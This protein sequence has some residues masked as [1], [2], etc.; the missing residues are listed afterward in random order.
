MSDSDEFLALL[1]RESPSLLLAMTGLASAIAKRQPDKRA[2]ATQTLTDTLAKIMSGADVLGRQDVAEAHGLKP[3]GGRSVGG[4]GGG[5]VTMPPAGGSGGDSMLDSIMKRYKAWHAPTLADDASGLIE[6]RIKK[7]FEEG[8][9]SA[10]AVLEDV[11]DWTVAY[12][13]TVYRTNV[14]S[15]YAAGN[16]AESM[17]P[18]ILE[19]VPAKLYTAVGDN[20]TRPNHLAADGLLAGVTDPIWDIFAPPMGFRCRCSAIDIDR[21]ELEDRKL[22]NPDGS[23]IRVTPPTFASAFPDPGFGTGRP[24]KRVYGR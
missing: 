14:A 11:N 19:I 1:E 5:G 8:R 24:D 7:S 17:E 16:W 3:G 13:D 9:D 15:A 10:L 23:V 22:L 2:T 20:D 6:D 18:D 4:G 12:A 21:F